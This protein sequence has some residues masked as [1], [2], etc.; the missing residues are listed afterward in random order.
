[1]ALQL[2]EEEDSGE[3]SWEAQKDSIRR[4]LHKA[5]SKLLIL[6]KLSGASTFPF[7]TQGR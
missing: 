5:G 3:D 6:G 4:A 1:M 7:G 2:L